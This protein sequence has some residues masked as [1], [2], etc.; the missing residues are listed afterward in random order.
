MLYSG[1]NHLED[2]DTIHRVAQL[3]KE[4]GFTKII[5][6]LG[7][8]AKQQEIAIKKQND[9]ILSN[10][11]EITFLLLMDCYKTAGKKN[12]KFIRQTLTGEF[13]LIALDKIGWTKEYQSPKM[14]EA[15]ETVM[16]W[17]FE[18]KNR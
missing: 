17:I 7:E 8:I 5:R 16:N 15:H 11:F 4:K 18:A 14:K 10:A 3:L 1:M 12:Q 13:F 2:D 9:G 6:S